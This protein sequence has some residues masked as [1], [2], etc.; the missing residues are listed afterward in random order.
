MSHAAACAMVF[1]WGPRD[2]DDLTPCELAEWGQFAER[3]GR[4]R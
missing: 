1:H 2:F 3:V 4:G